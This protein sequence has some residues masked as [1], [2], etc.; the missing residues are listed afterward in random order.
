MTST[1]PSRALII[2][3][4]AAVYI[5][6]G[7]TYLGIRLAIQTLPP[8]LMAAMRFL[9]AGGILF[10]VSIFNGAR[11]YQSFAKW[12]RALLIGTLLVVPVGDGTVVGLDFQRGSQRQ[13]TECE[14]VTRNLRRTR[15]CSVVSK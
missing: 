15:G 6:W 3:A 1:R 11:F 10:I 7:S 8:F 2:L 13:T 5:I 12:R 9:I 14:S 4:F